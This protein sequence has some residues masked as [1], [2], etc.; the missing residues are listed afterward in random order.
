MKHKNER[1]TAAGESKISLI[2]NKSI[3]LSEF[4]SANSAEWC[5]WRRTK[6]QQQQPNNCRFRFLFLYDAPV[7]V[8]WLHRL[9]AC[10]LLRPNIIEYEHGLHFSRAS[11]F[12]LIYYF[13]AS[14]EH[15]HIDL[16]PLRSSLVIAPLLVFSIHYLHTQIVMRVLEYI[17]YYISSQF[18]CSSNK[19]Q[20]AIIHSFNITCYNGKCIQNT[21]I[22]DFPMLLIMHVCCVWYTFT[23]HC[24]FIMIMIM[25]I[26]FFIFSVFIELVEINQKTKKNKTPDDDAGLLSD[27][28]YRSLNWR[29]FVYVVWYK[30]KRHCQSCVS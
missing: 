13:S 6:Q 30:S 7:G 11:T 22:F 16:F 24:R 25:I 4:I 14:L 26:N 28:Y 8:V 1:H 17:I 2:T 21:V 20:I 15:T 23:H 19:M 29:K 10:L 12:T 18:F 5:E 9:C 27:S 3:G